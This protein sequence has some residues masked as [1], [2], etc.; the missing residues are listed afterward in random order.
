MAR[1][2]SYKSEYQ[3]ILLIKVTKAAVVDPGLDP[4]SLDLY[5]YRIGCG[6]DFVSASGSRKEK[7]APQKR[8]FYVM[9]A[10]RSD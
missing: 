10:L 7:N 3:N 2:T 9:E 6:L 8:H 4:R 5:R 1:G